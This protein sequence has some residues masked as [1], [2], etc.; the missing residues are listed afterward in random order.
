VSASSAATLSFERERLASYVEREAFWREQRRRI[1]FI[2]GFLAILI[3]PPALVLDNIHCG[4]GQDDAARNQAYEIG[5]SVALFE[6]QNGRLPLH[7]DELTQP[8]GPR[9]PIMESMP[10]DPWG[11]SYTYAVAGIRDGTRFTIASAGRDG[12]FF[13]GDELGNWFN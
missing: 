13:T 5:K 4:R 6:L 2:A 12:E 9:R 10:L 8:Q 1:A 7:L 3:G 11:R